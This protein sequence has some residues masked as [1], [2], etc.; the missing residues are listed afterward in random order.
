MTVLF[1]PVSL[2]TAILKTIPILSP[3]IKTLLSLVSSSQIS[4]IFLSQEV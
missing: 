3:F 4:S 1:Q 2:H